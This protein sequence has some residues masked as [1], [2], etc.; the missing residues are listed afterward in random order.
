MRFFNIEINKKGIYKIPNEKAY[1]YHTLLPGFTPTQSQLILEQSGYFTGT[2]IYRKLWVA[3]RCVNLISENFASLPF[4]VSDS[5][6]NKIEDEPKFTKFMENPNNDDNGVEFR[7]SFCIYVL[8]NGN[9]YIW[10]NG[11]EGFNNTDFWVLQSQN[12]QVIGTNDIIKQVRRYEYSENGQ[13]KHFEP[14]ELMSMKLF[15]PDSRIVG[16]P[17]L[18]SAYKEAEYLKLTDTYKNSLFK[19][20]AVPSGIFSTKDIHSDTEFKIMQ[21]RLNSEY[22]GVKNAGK[23]IFLEGG[24]GYQQTAFKP[25]DLNLIKSELVTESAIAT[26]YGVPLEM[27]G[28]LEEKKNRANY[29]EA[30]T[31]FYIETILPFAEKFV[32]M[33]NNWFYP[34]R[35]KKIKIDKSEIPELKPTNEEL[36]KQYWTS[37][38]HKRTI[39]GVMKDENP[40]ADKLLVPNNLIP[41]EDLVDKEDVN[42]L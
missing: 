38:N 35:S 31:A 16:L 14:E 15:N 24:L 2:A 5:K 17:K 26:L 1:G 3:T 42:N 40:N 39:Q 32:K 27:L 4:Y 19:N 18:T 13:E 21:D 37:I 41:L 6:G 11:V 30:R 29:K 33:L 8:L 12:M 34:D 28:H 9:G 20:Q 7:E 22:A 23:T 25:T 36:S 10:Q